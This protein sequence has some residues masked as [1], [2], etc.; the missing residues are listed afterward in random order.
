MKRLIPFSAL[1]AA[2]LAA[3]G[4]KDDTTFAAAP[5]ND[6]PAN[7]TPASEVPALDPLSILVAKT[8]TGQ[9]RGTTSSSGGAVASA[10]LGVPY[11]APPVGDLR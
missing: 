8:E 1:L 9:I 4:G 10:F 5:A 3:C 2:L 6:T 11:A 7:D